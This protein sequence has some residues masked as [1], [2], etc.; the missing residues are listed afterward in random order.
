MDDREK[1]SFYF[2]F[3]FRLCFMF[4]VESDWQQLQHDKNLK[5]TLKW[6]KYYWSNLERIQLNYFKISYIGKL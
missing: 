5:H 1:L 3:H 6:C 2:K 4:L